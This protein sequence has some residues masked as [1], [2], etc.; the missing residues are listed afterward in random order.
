MR[1]LGQ[2]FQKTLGVT[3]L[4]SEISCVVDRAKLTKL[5]H[6]SSSQFHLFLEKTEIL[7]FR[8]LEGRRCDEIQFEW[9]H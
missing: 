6:C 9:I 4:V 2:K 7:T 8:P 3:R 5:G 1:I